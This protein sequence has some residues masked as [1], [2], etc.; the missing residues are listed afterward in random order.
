VRDG[1]LITRAFAR[2]GSGVEARET[3]MG[4]WP[5]RWDDLENSAFTTTPRLEHHD[6]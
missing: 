5:I 6:L 3:K 1:V 4:A 2:R